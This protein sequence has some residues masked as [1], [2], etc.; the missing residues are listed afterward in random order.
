MQDIRWLAAHR[1]P[2]GIVQKGAARP[3]RPSR[4]LSARPRDHGGPLFHEIVAIGRDLPAV[5]LRRPRP[6][7]A[8]LDAA[9]AGDERGRTASWSRSATTRRTP[10]YTYRKAKLIELL[11]ITPDEERS[12]TRLISDAEKERRRTERRRAAGKVERAEYKARAA[13]R[14]PTVRAMR[15]EGKS[16]AQIAAAHGISRE[17]ARRLAK[18]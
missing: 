9:A 14:R 3:V 18:T 16:W 15:A 13:A 11:G 7:R 5:R 8:Q 17:E 12:M 10:I 6:P 1:Y 2:N 4:G